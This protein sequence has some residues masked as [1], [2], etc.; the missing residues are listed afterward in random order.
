MARKGE[1]MKV[2]VYSLKGT[3]KGSLSVEKAFSKPVRTDLIRKVAGAEQAA[4]RQPYGTDPQ[5]GMKSSATY[6]GRRGVKHSM[7]NREMARMKRIITT[8]TLYMRARIVPQAVKGRKAHPPKAEKVWTIKINK[9]E[10]MAALLSA[11]SATTRKEWVERHGHDLSYVKHVPLVV[12]DELQSVSVVKDFRQVLDNLGLAEEVA[13]LAGK[14]VRSGKGTMRGRRY[15]RKRG[16]LFVIAEDKG[17]VKAARNFPGVEICEVT[18]LGVEMLAPGTNPG[19]LCV[20]TESA[21]KK[22]EGL[23]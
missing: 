15:K 22:L 11:A 23:A 9:K 16:M 10:R 1:K 3:E 21:V 2:P 13:R 7:M 6:R 19:R 14:K 17:F 4:M 18:N 12:D 20:W 8:R 5:A